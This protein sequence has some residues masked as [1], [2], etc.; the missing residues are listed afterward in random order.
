MFLLVL[1]K[2]E[3]EMKIAGYHL[4]VGSMFEKVNRERNRLA[5][6]NMNLL[7]NRRVCCLAFAAYVCQKLSMSNTDK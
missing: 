7:D 1:K 5:F 3:G 6:I 2:K 4:L